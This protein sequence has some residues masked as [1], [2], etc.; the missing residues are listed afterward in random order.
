MGA[1]GGDTPSFGSSNCCFG[2]ALECS[3]VFSNARRRSVSEIDDRTFA[4]LWECQTSSIACLYSGHRAVGGGGA[5]AVVKLAYRFA[6]DPTPAQKRALRSHAGAARFAWN[7][8]LARCRDRYAAERKWYSGAELHKLWNT[9]K[10]ADPALG[11]WGENSKCCYQQEVLGL[12]DGESQAVP[13]RADVPVRCLR[14]GPRPGRERR[15]QPVAPRGQWGREAKRLPRDRKTAPRAASP[16]ETG[17]RHPARGQDRDRPPATEGGGMSESPLI[18]HPQR[19]DFS[20]ELYG[21]RACR[22]AIGHA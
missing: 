3:D 20:R 19:I 22:R 1:G 6:L 12:R 5:V 9:A 8:A 14:P 17:T 4:C 2:G 16:R 15:P 7:W 21:R 18:T 11:W 10:K 13:G